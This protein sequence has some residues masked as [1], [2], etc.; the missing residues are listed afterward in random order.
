MRECDDE[1][2]RRGRVFIDFEA[3][4]EEVGELVG[5]VQRGVLRRSDVAGT[6]AELAVGTVEG[7][8]SEDE[9][10]VFKS[11]GTTAVNL[12]AAQLAFETHVATTKNG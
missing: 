1:A 2:M 12:L 9:I 10:T 8:R 6:L 7:R 11:I 3:A 5:A 4:M